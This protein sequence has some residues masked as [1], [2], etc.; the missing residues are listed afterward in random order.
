MFDISKQA[1]ICPAPVKAQKFSRCLPR[2]SLVE[3]MACPPFTKLSEPVLNHFQVN[4]RIKLQWNLNQNSY[5][6]MPE[7]EVEI[8]NVV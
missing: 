2:P 8:E 7:N 3:I 1:K 5:I 6:F 4:P